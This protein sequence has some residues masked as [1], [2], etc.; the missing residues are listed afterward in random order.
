MRT[1]HLLSVLN[2][3]QQTLKTEHLSAATKKECLKKLNKIKNT[4]GKEVTIMIKDYLQ[5]HYANC[6]KIKESFVARI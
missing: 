1:A 6:R 5:I 3:L 2:S 4:K